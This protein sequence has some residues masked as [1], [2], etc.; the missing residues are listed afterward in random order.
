[1]PNKSDPREA[2]IRQQAEAIFELTKMSW[3]RRDNIKRKGEFDLSETEFLTLD[4]LRKRGSMT[5]GDL[6]RAIG[7]LPAQMSRIIR[8][9]ESKLA[10]PMVRCEINPKD[11]RK[12][13]V[14]LTETGAKAHG[15]YS[16]ARLAMSISVLQDLNDQDRHE[17]MRILGVMRGSFANRLKTK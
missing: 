3:A 1:M 14:S 13:D 9:L 17:F 15:T 10:K 8:S 12:V 4:L 11:K 2:E 7:V 16:E 5:V 6:Q